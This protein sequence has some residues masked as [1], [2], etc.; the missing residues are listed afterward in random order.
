MKNKKIGPTNS[1]YSEINEFG[2]VILVGGQ[3]TRMGRDKAFLKIGNKTFLQHVLQVVAPISSQTIV[4]INR[5]QEHLCVSPELADIF[6][7]ARDTKDRQGPLQGIADSLSTMSPNINY[8]YVLSCDLPYLTTEWLNQLKL[9]MQPGVDVVCTA[10]SG[11]TN[12]LLALYRK[13]VLLAAPELLA[14]NCHRPIKLWADR[15]IVQLTPEENQACVWMDVDTPQDY[16]KALHHFNPELAF[17][18]NS[19]RPSI[20]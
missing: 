14:N 15:N 17:F 3:S 10:I 16:Q 8:F 12:P 18:H 11:I 4:S 13:E 7:I 9:E 19:L 2:V 20:R 5:D 6:Q 1:K